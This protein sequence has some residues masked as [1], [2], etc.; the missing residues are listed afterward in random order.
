[1]EE[2]WDNLIILDA[3]RY[4]LFKE[5]WENRDYL[6]G[7]VKKAISPGTDTPSWCKNSFKEKY[8]DIVYISANPWINS[9]TKVRSFEAD[10][11]FFEIIDVWKWGWDE[12]LGTVHPHTVNKIATKLRNC[13]KRMI[14]H[15]MQPHYP[16]LIKDNY[17]NE[18]GQENLRR[19]KM[20]GQTVARNPMRAAL[21]ILR[22]FRGE[23]AKSPG[24]YA[25]RRSPEAVLV[26]YIKNLVLVMKYAEKM[27]RVLGGKI[28]V[29]SD[30]G[31]LLG[32]NSRYGHL[33][34]GF[35]PKLVEVPWLEV[36]R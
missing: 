22:K 12:N 19:M 11:H 36:E 20:L 5:V 27:T 16:Y 25:V 31:E 1:M 8:D 24:E 17:I 18:S 13:E 35:H 3:C 30:H 6:N 10:A 7:K 4:D 28:V 15:Y 21:W 33:E 14:I 2:H 34:L 29:T 26:G 9:E 23:S 32:E